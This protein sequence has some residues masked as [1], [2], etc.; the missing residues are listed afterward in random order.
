MIRKLHSIFCIIFGLVFYY[1]PCFAD[2]QSTLEANFPFVQTFNNL[3]DWTPSGYGDIVTKS[4][5]PVVTSTQETGAWRYY[6][7][8]STVHGA[9]I[10]E[11]AYTVNPFGE[12][13][14]KSLRI[15]LSDSG[16]GPSRLAADIRTS[17]HPNGFKWSD[18]VRVFYAIRRNNGFWASS[19]SGYSKEFVLNMECG[20]TSCSIANNN[21]AN[22]AVSPFFDYHHTH[23][24]GV[25]PAVL[26]SN[27][28][29]AYIQ[30]PSPR[31][32][33]RI[34]NDQWIF[35]E[36]LYTPNETNRTATL[37]GWIY[38]ANGNLLDKIFDN[39]SASVFNSTEWAA[40]SSGYFD[41]AMFGGNMFVTGSKSQI[42]FDDLIIDVDANGSI[43]DRYFALANGGIGTGDADRQIPYN[44]RLGS[45]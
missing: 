35:V 7:M 17:G 11:F 37:S 42:Y 22:Y 13:V 8:W 15:D 3:D 34:Y 38:D 30:E 18:G 25:N 32:D 44:L 40:S 29:G 24:N 31:T 5:M 36:Y 20:N 1:S 41:N 45:N 21:R 26:I 27:S 4:Y 2:W 6:S 10:D 39:K 16:L 14:S 19:P 28:N 23:E 33:M 9:G 12:S 43:A